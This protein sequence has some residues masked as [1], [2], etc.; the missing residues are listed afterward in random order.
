MGAKPAIAI[1]TLHFAGRA[2]L[3][4][5]PLAFAH[6]RY[7]YA[8]AS[9]IATSLL[10]LVERLGIAYFRTSVEASLTV[11]AVHCVFQQVPPG[12]STAQPVILQGA[13]DQARAELELV[14]TM[15]ADGLACVLVANGLVWESGMRLLSETALFAAVGIAV[16]LALRSRVARASAAAWDAQAAHTA[17]ILAALEGASE[18]VAAGRADAFERSVAAGLETVRRAA[19]VVRSQSLFARPYYWAS[20][21]VYGQD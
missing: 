20:F 4:L 13:A 19:R 11:K 21:A 1:A 17:R 5:S 2:T 8:F 3:I 9:G 18:I 12:A 10:F 16:V 7:A 6:S 14:P 15:A